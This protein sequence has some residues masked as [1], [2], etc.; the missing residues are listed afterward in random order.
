MPDFLCSVQI[1]RRLFP[2]M[3]SHALGCLAS[4]LGIAFTPGAHRAE[5]DASVTTHVLLRV[6]E[7]LRSRYAVP[8]V[9]VDLLRRFASAV[10]APAAVASAA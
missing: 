4:R 10:E 2:D 7:I 9:T 8:V 5:V 1:A 3:K 6:C